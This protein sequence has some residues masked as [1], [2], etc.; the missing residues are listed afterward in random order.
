LD[1]TTFLL[2][3]GQFDLK[4]SAGVQ[5]VRKEVLLLYMFPG[6]AKVEQLYHI[7]IL[8]ERVLMLLL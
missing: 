8:L 4:K 2:D 6:D 5:N 7:N 1:I 3:A